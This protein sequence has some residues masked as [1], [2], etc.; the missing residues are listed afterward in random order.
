MSLPTVGNGRSLRC[1]TTESLRT[2]AHF[3]AGLE[4][5]GHT[6]VAKVHRHPLGSMVEVVAVVHPDAGIVGLEGDLVGLAGRDVEGIRPPRAAAY[7]FAVA[8]QDEH[9]VAVQV[10]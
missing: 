3:L 6:F 1:P 4:R 2:V 5:R 10:H 8:A 7:G 9:V